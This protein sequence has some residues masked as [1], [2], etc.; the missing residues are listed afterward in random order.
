MVLLS[1]GYSFYYS[2]EIVNQNTE[3]NKNL[4]KIRFEKKKRED[5][6][7]EWA[8]NTSITILENNAATLKL[9]PIDKKIDE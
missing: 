9:K 6:N 5:L 3:L 7:I 1:L 4:E 2:S 8:K